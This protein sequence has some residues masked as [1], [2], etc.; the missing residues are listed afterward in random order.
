M[1]PSPAVH[2]LPSSTTGC[3]IHR[4]DHFVILA[5]P[6]ERAADALTLQAF[7]NVS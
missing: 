4:S 2:R 5:I 7:L 1:N 3:L 6:D